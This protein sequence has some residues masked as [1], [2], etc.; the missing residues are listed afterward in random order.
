MKLP[1]YQV[2]AFTR[3]PFTGNPAAVCPLESWLEE[4]IMQKIAMENNLSETAFFVREGDHFQLRWFTPVV[5]VDLCG[6]ATLATAYTLF[7][8]LGYGEEV[9]DF[10]TRSGMLSVRKAAVG[11]TMDFPADRVIPVEIDR[12]LIRALG[13]TPAFV[14]QGRS[15]V[16][17]VFENPEEIR[18]MAPDFNLLGQRGGRGTIVTAPG[19]EGFDF[20]SRGFFPQSGI[21]ED[22][23]TGSAHTTLTP[24]WSQRLGKKRLEACQVSLRKG[25]FSC[26]D[27]GDRVLLTGQ[28]RRYMEGTLYI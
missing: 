12:H 27:R 5:E 7:E 9:I 6:H 17:C 23:A 2:D 18:A 3:G 1:I 24:Y 16:M 28:A 19:D 13:I 22:P 14:F 21:N 20:I 15:D 25:Y 8:M 4:D 10:D 11:M 26:E